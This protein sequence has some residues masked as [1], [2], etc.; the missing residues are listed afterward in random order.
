MDPFS[1]RN[2][3][4]GG[5]NSEADFI[6][7]TKSNNI[8]GGKAKESNPADFEKN[9]GVAVGGAYSPN[10]YSKAGDSDVRNS[11]PGCGVMF[12]MY[13]RLICYFSV[14]II[15]L[16]TVV[17]I[18]IILND[19]LNDKNAC[20]F[21]MQQADVNGGAEA[22]GNA[23]ACNYVQFANAAAIIIAFPFL[24]MTTWYAC[25][26][27]IRPSKV[28]VAEVILACLMFIL[29][30]ATLASISLQTEALCKQ[31][32]TETSTSCEAR[33]V[34]YG[35]DSSKQGF[36]ELYPRLIIMEQ[37][38]YAGEVAWAVLVIFMIYRY[39]IVQRMLRP[40]TEVAPVVQAPA[41][42]HKHVS[43]SLNVDGATTNANTLTE[44]LLDP[45]DE[46]DEAPS[47]SSWSKK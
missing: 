22:S 45:M 27:R 30:S 16:V 47:Q 46:E 25:H 1:D 2:F 11:N 43:I 18:R 38:A 7:M 9:N 39:K 29:Q 15:S 24:C 23:S 14:V 31:F 37:C 17:T 26:K 3:N 28:I 41:V 19:N 44:Q 34:K 10:P 13:I 8:K 20:P 35:T 21:G 12:Q 5:P 33:L 40:S 42:H 6:A 4:D 32:S 36:G